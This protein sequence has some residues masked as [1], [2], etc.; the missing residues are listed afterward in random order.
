MQRR[1]PEADRARL[2]QKLEQVRLAREQVRTALQREPYQAAQ[3]E[4][5]LATLRERAAELQLDM[6][7]QL[8]DTAARL[9]S[10]QRRRLADSRF[11]RPRMPPAP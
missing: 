6:H 7:K 10:E 5:A 1:L 9:P 8:L 11:L 3:L 2:R 4:A